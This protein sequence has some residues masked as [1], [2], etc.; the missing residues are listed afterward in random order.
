MVAPRA[1]AAVTTPPNPEFEAVVRESFARQGLMR[2]IGAWLAVVE[3]GRV[4]IELP[5]SERLSQQGGHFHGA[6]AG[7][8]GDTAGGYAA[9]TMMPAGSEVLTVE[10]KINFVRPA[11]GQ[12]LRADARVVR[13]GKTLSVAQVDLAIVDAAATTSVAF[14]QATFM[15]AP[16]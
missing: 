12:V 9:L 8:I 11:A 7:A 6:I 16:A 15:R 2:Q 4:V 14:I 5:F 10:Y 3:P 13:T 1:A